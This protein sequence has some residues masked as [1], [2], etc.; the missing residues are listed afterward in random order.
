[1]VREQARQEMNLPA[2][3]PEV[4][5]VVV[6]AL[7]RHRNLPETTEMR[8]A[9]GRWVKQSKRRVADGRV[10][11]VYT[12]IIDA[13]RREAEIAESEERYRRVVEGSP[14]AM[15]VCCVD[16]I[17]YANQA[18]VRLFGASSEAG[19]VG[20]SRQRLRIAGEEG[21]PEMRSSGPGSADQLAQI[22]SQKRLRLGGSVVDVDVSSVRILWYGE[23]AL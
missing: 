2:D 20:L 9:D 15:M 3:H 6:R 4:D 8:R 7:E 14:D 11:A 10:V 23:Q 1:M 21:L 5:N 17:V 13:K 16:K 19:L 22:E 18:S 12:D